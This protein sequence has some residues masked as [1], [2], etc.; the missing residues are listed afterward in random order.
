MHAARRPRPDCCRCRS[1]RQAAARRCV[2]CW[3]A[4]RRRPTTPRAARTPPTRCGWRWNARRPR[5]PIRR[6]G[7]APVAGTAAGLPVPAE[8]RAAHPADGDPGLRLEPAAAGRDLGRRVPAAVPAPDRRRVGPARPPGGRPARLLRDRVR[9]PAAAA[10]LVRHAAGARGRDRVPAAGRTPPVRGLRARAAG[11]LGRPRP[12]G[13]GLREP[14]GNAVRPQ[15]GRDPVR[16]HRALPGRRARRVVTVADDGA[17]M[18]RGRGRRRSS[19]PAAPRSQRRC[20]ARAV[21]RQGHRRGARRPDRADPPAAGHVLPDLPAGRSRGPARW[22]AEPGRAEAVAD[23]AMACDRGRASSAEGRCQSRLRQ[24]HPG[25]GGGGRPE[26][27]G[28]DPVQPGRA[29]LRHRGVRRRRCARCNC[30]RPRS[31]TSSC[32]T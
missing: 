28:P 14:A 9:H 22:P 19:P 6:R 11:G 18:P 15:P 1:R 30:W 13:A 32:S 23:D 29:R 20:R 10:G 8:P 27:R 21:H 12:A 2:A 5:S 26:H 24:R 17:G 31:R 3:Q 25:A 4:L 7:A 16:V